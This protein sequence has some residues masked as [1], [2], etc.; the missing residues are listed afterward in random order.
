M[1]QKASTS[2]P[3]DDLE[4]ATAGLRAALRH[5]ALDAGAPGLPDWSTLAVTGP[6]MAAD[7]RGRPWFT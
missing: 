6:E 4:W 7:E 5:R 1:A 2:M 3:Y